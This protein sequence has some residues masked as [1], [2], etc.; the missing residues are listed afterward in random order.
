MKKVIIKNNGFTLVELL[1]VIA[2][3]AILVAMVMPKI[4]E[5]YNKTKINVFVTDTQ[6][7]MKSAKSKFMLESLNN[8]STA[9]YYSSQENTYLNTKKIDID[10]DNEYFIEMD[11]N[12]YFKRIVI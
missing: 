12:G 8:N 6:T 11:R 9:Q 7:F 4:M 10:S 3:V 1:A 5:Q 2:I